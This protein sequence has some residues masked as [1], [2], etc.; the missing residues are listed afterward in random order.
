QLL[1]AGQT[2]AGYRVLLFDLLNVDAWVF[3]RRAQQSHQVA[4]RSLEALGGLGASHI[5]VQYPRDVA[6]QLIE[7]EP[8]QDWS[9]VEQQANHAEGEEQLQID[10]AR[11]HLAYP[12]R[13]KLENERSPHYSGLAPFS[14]VPNMPEVLSEKG[15]NNPNRG[16]SALSSV[17]V[18]SQIRG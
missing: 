14:G 2:L 6:G 17:Q 3:R 1:G 4:D 8:G 10:A 16:A 9:S 13:A 15:R 7:Q 11:E 5:F 12:L 18:E